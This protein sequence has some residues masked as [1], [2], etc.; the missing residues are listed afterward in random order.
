MLLSSPLSWAMGSG[1]SKSKPSVAA[2]SAEANDGKLKCALISTPFQGR[3]TLFNPGAVSWPYVLDPAASS[4]SQS[5]QREKNIELCRDA[6]CSA[7]VCAT[8]LQRSHVRGE[9]LP[10]TSVRDLI[11]QQQFD[12]EAAVKHF[13]EEAATVRVLLFVWR[14]SYPIPFLLGLMTERSGTFIA[15]PRI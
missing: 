1:R 12:L 11:S 14:V 8:L 9:T 7:L 6:L 4:F 15:G 13:D 3:S 2:S 5:A 10:L